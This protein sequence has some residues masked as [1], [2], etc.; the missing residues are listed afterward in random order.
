MLAC[1][2]VHT[3]ADTD[4]GSGTLV[5]RDEAAYWCDSVDV[6][7]GVR[8]EQTELGVVE[9]TK[10]CGC[11]IEVANGDIGGRSTSS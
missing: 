3:E 1:E 7:V 10:C 6:A 4:I 11:P 9:A 2:D 8:G 5:M